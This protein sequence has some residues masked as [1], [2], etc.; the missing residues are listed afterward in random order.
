MQVIENFFFTPIHPANILISDLFPHALF[1]GSSSK[2][3]SPFASEDVL[4]G[5]S[6]F[7]S[8]QE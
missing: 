1:Q 4:I 5:L 8:V 3:R 7:T 2:Q 6:T